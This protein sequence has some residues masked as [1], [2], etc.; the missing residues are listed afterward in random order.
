MQF[1]HNNPVS[2]REID[3]LLCR[4]H[5]VDQGVPAAIDSNGMI[6]D[7]H[8]CQKEARCSDLGAFSLRDDVC[9]GGDGFCVLGDGNMALA[10]AIKY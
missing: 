6:R 8:H 4:S 1:L 3:I 10:L 9:G 2:E 7:S 5:L